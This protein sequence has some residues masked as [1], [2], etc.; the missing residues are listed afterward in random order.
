MIVVR[1]VFQAHYGQGDA[2]VKLFQEAL[3][4]WPA[5]R[6]ARVLT[7]LSG[8][9]FTVITEAEFDSLSHWEAMAREFFADARFADWFERMTPLV[10][11]GRREFYSL[12]G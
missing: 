1:N 8:T 12:A 10:E 7:D 11:S 9:F 4:T 6:N 3:A 2:L 5:G